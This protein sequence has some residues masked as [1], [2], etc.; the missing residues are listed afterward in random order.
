VSAK[1]LK[2]LQCSWQVRLLIK[3]RKK[4]FTEEDVV[5]PA[6]EHESKRLGDKIENLWNSEENSSKIP[7]LTRVLVKM[8]GFR[9]ILYGMVY[10]IPDLAVW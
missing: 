3:K 4:K 7:S 8:F 10:C 9:M 5:R 6:K 2:P 1:P